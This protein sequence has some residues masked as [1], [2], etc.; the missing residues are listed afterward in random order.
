MFFINR[1][2][3]C[4][5]FFFLFN[6]G[7][8]LFVYISGKLPTNHFI[9]RQHKRES[10]T[11]HLSTHSTL[12]HITEQ[13]SA[14]NYPNS[15]SQ[16]WSNASLKYFLWPEVWLWHWQ[17]HILQWKQTDIMYHDVVLKYALAITFSC[18]FHSPAFRV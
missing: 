2:Q 15:F 9:K 11:N 10:E 3:S 4:L 12:Q 8:L 16:G 18:G 17:W 13:C 6:A 7:N 14:Q 1:Y 5:F